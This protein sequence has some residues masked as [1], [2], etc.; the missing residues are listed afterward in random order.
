[1]V[2]AD[3]LAVWKPCAA[4]GTETGTDAG[5]RPDD[6]AETGLTGAAADEAGSYG[7][8]YVDASR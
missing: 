2:S 4:E 8:V 6:D 1:M 5:G 3:A 7:L